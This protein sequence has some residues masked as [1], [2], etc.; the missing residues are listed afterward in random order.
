MEAKNQSLR[1]VVWYRKINWGPFTTLVLLPI[2]GL[3]ST[4]WVKPHYK[5]TSFALAYLVLVA[6]SVTA[7][8]MNTYKTNTVLVLDQWN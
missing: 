6:L 5:T 2:F 8:K 4:F 3:I 7:G 1:T